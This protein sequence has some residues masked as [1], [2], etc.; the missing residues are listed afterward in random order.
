MTVTHYALVHLRN[1]E[2]TRFDKRTA[3]QIKT[4]LR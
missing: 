3:A 1:E 4:L 2:R